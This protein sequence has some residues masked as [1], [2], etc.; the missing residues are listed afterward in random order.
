MVGALGVLPVVEQRVSTPIRLQ[1]PENPVSVACGARHSAAVTLEGRLWLCGDNNSGQLGLGRRSQME[2]SWTESELRDVISVAC[3]EKF[4]VAHTG[5]GIWVTG[6][7]R[8]GQLG[9]GP[10]TEDGFTGWQRLPLPPDSGEIMQLACCWY[11]LFVLTTT[12][13]WACGDNE[14]GQLG[15]GDTAKRDVLTRVPLEEVEW[16]RCGGSSVYAMRRNGLYEWG[17]NLSGQIGSAATGVSIIPR[18][19]LTTL[20]IAGHIY[21]IA[22][23][24][25]HVIVCGVEVKGNVRMSYTVSSGSRAWGQ[26][27]VVDEGTRRVFRLYAGYNS[28]F[29]LTA[30][31][32]W[33][34]GGNAE[35]QLGLGGP[36]SRAVLTPGGELVAIAM[37]AAI[38]VKKPATEELQDDRDRQRRR[39]QGLLCARCDRD[40]LAI[41][42]RHNRYQFCGDDCYEQF[43]VHAMRR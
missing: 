29:A 7:G 31:G 21:D 5:D 23:G 8:F 27:E 2:T 13:L 37:Q 35:C 19:T 12:G 1:G 25:A 16:I 22:V 18:P 42:T 30:D 41:E 33:A 3:G 6:D 20:D 4:T 36:P 15:Q 9:L 26:R 34:S 28:S 32:L 43:S 10:I 17:S 38:R 14:Y 24:G 40:A 11:S 39:L